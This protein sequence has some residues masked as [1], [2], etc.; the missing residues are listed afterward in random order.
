MFEIVSKLKANGRKP[1]DRILFW[2]R[3][4]ALEFK[5]FE[6]SKMWVGGWDSLN[7][8]TYAY[9]GLLVWWKGSVFSFGIE[10]HL[11]G[12]ED[13]MQFLVLSAGEGIFGGY[14]S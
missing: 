8:Y 10:F 13:C 9:M 14:S 5:L 6:T 12:I 1:K 3:Q 2:S 4:H 11:C 7:R